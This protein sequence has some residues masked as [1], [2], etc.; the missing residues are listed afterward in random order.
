MRS[1]VRVAGH[2]VHPMLIVVPSTIFPLLVF[3]DVLYFFGV[4]GE[5]LWVAAYWIAVAGVASTAAAIVPGVVDL[6]AI[7]NETRAHRTAVWHLVTGSLT[8]VA[9]A[10]AVWARWP[11]GVERF[12]L[13]TGIDVV[14]TALIVVQGWLGG[15]LVYKHHLAVLKEAEGAEP[16]DFEP[17]GHAKRSRRGAVG[18]VGRRR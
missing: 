15:E 7:P 18:E 3:L 2:P 4:G 9:Y 6:A 1:R 8:F 17:R 5:G 13:Q 12:A 10:A 14:G 11:A 16:T